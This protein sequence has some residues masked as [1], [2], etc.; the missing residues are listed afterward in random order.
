MPE[1][2]VRV[3]NQQFVKKW[4]TSCGFKTK[5]D[6]SFTGQLISKRNFSVFKSTKKN[7]GIF[8]R[9]SALTSKKRDQMKNNF[10]VLIRSYFNIT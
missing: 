5:F 4:P 7:K 3:Q 10:I 1:F 9:I 8:V 6:S 2:V